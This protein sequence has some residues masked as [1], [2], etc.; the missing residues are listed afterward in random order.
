MS[1][2]FDDLKADDEETETA[3]STTETETESN[4]ESPPGETDEA[5]SKPTAS[6][7]SPNNEPSSEPSPD[8]ESAAEST[9]DTTDEPASPAETGPA[10]EYSEVKQKPFYA[11]TETVNEFENAIRTTIVPTLAEADVID[12][13]TREIHDAVLRLAN[14]EPERIAELVLEERRQAGEQ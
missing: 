6:D 11:R 9:T 4:A 8:I 1:N 3:D 2:P 5:A 7:S 12:E 10:F 13:E 14:E